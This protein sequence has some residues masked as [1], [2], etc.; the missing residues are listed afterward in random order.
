MKSGVDMQCCE[1][2][3]EE[4]GAGNSHAGFRGGWSCC[5]AALLPGGSRRRLCGIPI[6]RNKKHARLNEI[7]NMHP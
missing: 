5:K 3:S 6:S 4:P 7:H 1:S 2:I